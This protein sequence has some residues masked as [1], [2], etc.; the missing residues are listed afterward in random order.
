MQEVSLFGHGYKK[1]RSKKDERKIDRIGDN[2]AL[3]DLSSYSGP[4][5]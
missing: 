5:Q 4:W 2:F 1:S 3:S